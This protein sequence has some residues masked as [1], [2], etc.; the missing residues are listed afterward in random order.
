MIAYEISPT[1]EFSAIQIGNGTIYHQRGEYQLTDSELILP[2]NRSYRPQIPAV[3]NPHSHPE[4]FIYD[5]LINDTVPDDAELYDKEHRIRMFGKTLLVVGLESSDDIS[6]TF[7]SKYLDNSSASRNAFQVLDSMA[8]RLEKSGCTATLGL[9]GSHMVGLNGVESDM[10]LV[11]WASRDERE[12]TLELIDDTLQSLGYIPANDTAK[13]DEYSI[14][15]ANLTGLSKKTGAYLASQRNR[16]I[17]PNGT[18]TSLQLIHSDYDHG[19]AKSILEGALNN[20]LEYS[21]TVTDLHVS[22]IPG[23]EPFNYPRI[24]NVDAHG[25][26]VQVISFNMVH[27][28]MGTNGLNA[29]SDIGECALT[30]SRYNLYDG[31]IVYCLQENGDYI[32]PVNLVA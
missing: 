23:S 21:E 5:K 28:G 24:W 10:D 4:K 12:E 32:L 11:A 16:W 13:F 19:T 29:D 31:R 22:V 3:I 15:I 17:S 6:Q 8:I 25:Q 30:G 20:E 18:G 2:V 7:S 14:R 27:Q 26:N 1:P 9:H